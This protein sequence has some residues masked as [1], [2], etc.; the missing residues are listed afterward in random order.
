M[1]FSVL[2]CRKHLSSHSLL[3]VRVFAGWDNKIYCN[4]YLHAPRCNLKY[5]LMILGLKI[6]A[7]L[8][9]TIEGV[10]GIRPLVTFDA[11]SNSPRHS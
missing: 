1:K 2:S 3:P 10:C 8:K 11:M 9:V 4:R 5:S 7:S 6:N